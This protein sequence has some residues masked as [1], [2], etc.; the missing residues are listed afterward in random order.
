MTKQV[1]LLKTRLSLQTATKVLMR[2]AYFL[3][4]I[5]G[6]LL[7]SGSILWSLNLDLARYIWL[8][9]PISLPTKL[10]FFFD[11]YKSIYTTYSSVQG[12]TIVVFSI[13]FGINLSLLVFVLKHRGFQAIPKKSGIGGFAV[14][15]VGGGC[16]AC[17]TSLL[18][19]LLATFG[20]TAT[21]LIRDLATI[22]MS[23]GIV[24]ITYSIYKLGAV[25][26]YI[27]A[28]QNL[29]KD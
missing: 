2:P 28:T 20:A 10:G 24:L 4:A 19:P 17:G 3:L 26:V 8:E 22:F 23:V 15:I 12:T 11:V 16:I 29:T 14:A 7:A 13:L 27:F 25:A 21:P 6:T 18:A 1:L 9:A 5:L